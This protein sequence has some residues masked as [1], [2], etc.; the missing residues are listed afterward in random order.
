MTKSRT[1]IA[2]PPGVTIK[3]QL[4]G[5]G[6]TQKEFA[7]RMGYSQKHITQLIKGDVQLTPETANRLEM[8]LG[9]PA[10]F[11]NNLESIYREKL[12]KT[13][14]E[15]QMDDEI[16]IA[17]EFPYSEMAKQGW[18]DSAKAP[19]ERVVQLR[20]YFEVASL[21]SLSKEEQLLPIACRRK[22]ET[23][24]ADYALL[25][26]AQQAKREARG[27]EVSK[28]DLG[29]LSGSLDEIRAMTV[30]DPAVFSPRLVELLADCGIA[31]VYLPHIG[32]SFLNGA[33]FY[34]GSKIVMGV[35]V[36]GK[37]S[38]IFWFS[39]FHELGHILYGHV[40]QEGG[41]TDED[42]AAA[43]RFAANLLIPDDEF[44]VLKCWG[45]FPSEDVRLFSKEIG[46]DP[47]IVVGRLQKEGLIGYGQLNGLKT[48]YRI[49]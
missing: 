21:R 28:V 43:D 48:K 41:T 44:A 5:R 17:R 12:Q 1:Y 8:V 26:W 35:T 6:M 49:V 27:I 30:Q 24:R 45:R 19:K 18:V 10:R 38:D 37:T 15:N 47:G 33:S 36:R 29:K 34:D 13:K 42:E 3:E 25:A 32:G 22:K 11:W 4:D 16:V 20:R 40:G 7:L 39:L 31:L 9:I 2:I 46:V 23:D 14:D